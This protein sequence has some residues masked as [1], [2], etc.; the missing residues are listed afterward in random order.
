MAVEYSSAV[1]QKEVVDE[2][3]YTQE[4]LAER[5]T[6]MC[7]KKGVHHTRRAQLGILAT[8]V[9]SDDRYAMNI[10]ITASDR[11]VLQ[12]C[13]SGG[14]LQGEGYVKKIWNSLLPNC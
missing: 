11:A 1:L 8:M 2:P 4:D 10:P 14:Y 5:V 6:R 3:T 12:M 9:E 13:K 7:N